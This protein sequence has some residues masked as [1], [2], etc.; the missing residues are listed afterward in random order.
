M[1]VH[2]VYAQM[3]HNGIRGLG[4]FPGQAGSG[5]PQEVEIRKGTMQPSPSVRPSCGDRA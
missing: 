3:A 5:L 4:V 2:A 1:S